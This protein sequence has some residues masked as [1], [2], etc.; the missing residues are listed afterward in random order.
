MQY[1]FTPA[2]LNALGFFGGTI[3]DITLELVSSLGGKFDAQIYLGCTNLTEYANTTFIP[4]SSLTQVHAVGKYDA[5]VGFHTF[6]FN[7]TDYDWDG[8]STLVVQFCTAE[9]QTNGT[10]TIRYGTST[11][12]NRCMYDYTST[13]TSCAE[14]IGSRTTNRPNIG[15]GFCQQS[16]SSPTYNWVPATGLSSSTAASPTATPTATT[17]YV[18]NVT[19]GGSG[20][21][22]SGIATINVGA[23]F[24]LAV[25]ASSTSLCFSGTSNLLATPTGAG[26]PYTYTW[27]PAA[28]LSNASIANPVATPGSTTTYFVTVTGAGGTCEKYGNI[29]INVSGNPVSASTSLDNICPGTAVVLDVSSIPQSCGLNP[30]GCSGSATTADVGTTTTASS[31]YGPFYGGY[32]DVRYQFLY[33]AADLTGMGL[34]AGTITQIGFD[35]STKSTTGAFNGFTLKMGCTN[36][37]ALSTTAWETTAGAVYGP[38]NYTSTLGWNMFTL[39]TPF[40]WDGVS[41]IVIESCFDNS[42]TV[43]S[44]SYRYNSPGF[45]STMRN[46]SNT[47]GPGCTMP[48]VYTYTSRPNLR[49]TV[50]NSSMPVGATFLWDNAADLN[51]ATL[52]SPTATPA[53]TTT[54]NVSVTDPANP[55]CPSVGNV[56]VNVQDVQV[57]ITPAGPVGICTGDP[58]VA[59]S[60]QLM[61]NGAPA[62][63]GTGA[64]CYDQ[65][66]NFTNPGL[67]NG[68]NNF[69]FPGTPT[70]SVGGTLTV[71]AYGDLDMATELWTIRDETGTDLGTC[72][73]SLTQCGTT[74]TTIIPLT[75]VQINAWAANG[76]IDFSGVDVSG[77]INATL[78]AVGADMLELRLQYDCPAGSGYTWTPSAG[79][80]DP[81]IQNPT[82]NPA[83]STSYQVESVYG[84]CTVVNTIDVNVGTASTAPTMTPMPG[85]HC[86]NTTLTLNAGGGTAGVGSSIEW[87]TGANGTGTWLGS[88]AS[89]NITPTTTGQTY[90]IRREGGCNI[91]ADDMVTI[92]LK[93]YV[94]GLNGTVSGTYCTDNAGWHHFFN[95]DEILLSIRGDLSTMPVGR[96]RVRINDNGSFFQQTQGPSTAPLCASTNIT[97]GE[98]RF[99][100]ER[101]WNV[102]IGTGTLSGTYE[103]RFYYEPAERTAIETAATNWMA[104]YPACGYTYKYPNPLGFYW[105]KNVG[106]NYSAPDYDGLHLGAAAGITPNGVNYGEL[107]G[108]TSFSGGSGAIILTPSILLPVQWLYFDG[109]TID[110]KI[111]SLRWA[112]ESESNSDHFNIQR[113][114]DG[115]SF[116]NIGSHAAQG[117]TTVTTHYTF[118]DENPFEG[119]NYYRLELVDAD[120]ETTYSSTILLVIASDGLGYNFYPNPTNDVVFYQYEAKQ[121]ENLRIEVLDVLGKQIISKDVISVLGTNNI[122]VD[123]TTFPAGT[124]MVRVHNQQNSAVHTVKVIKNKF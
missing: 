124:Y 87:Y 20:C 119:P 2:E 39:T 13:T 36:A 7:V 96:P 82:A 75:A 18:L 80:S 117:N 22:G 32:Q 110:N 101:S 38:V 79:L 33:T 45:T 29:T 95:N 67:L 5:T 77:A 113:S 81:A 70:G 71:R 48:P 8:T 103:V 73:G 57:D 15:F 98:E 49:F 63:G 14:L 118:D 37:T 43:G 84:G 90:Y 52:Q 93:D 104:T 30:G 66:I 44:D 91:T 34:S 89:L 42:A 74:H 92:N 114:K 107:A 106:S 9:F 111:N 51:N 47:V 17:A 56:T 121:K 102:N 85:T 86:P 83:S 40:D 59:L 50:C 78:C 1:L 108:I 24:N 3:E 65:T 28:S 97:P 88:G 21:T 26:G 72:G 53:A 10:S 60:A 31:T 19:D 68:T 100:M 69:N 4:T 35:V 99:E 64:N 61:V 58:A 116:E 46:Y 62:A 55:G 12:A 105:F 27:S 122:P 76:S 94:Y 54:Y 123:L 25:S 115:V 6:N 11:P 41:N 23:D 120:G 109:E 16:V 112:T